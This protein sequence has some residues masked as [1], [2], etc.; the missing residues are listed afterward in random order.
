MSHDLVE[1]YQALFEPLEKC[2]PNTLDAQ[3]LLLDMYRNLLRN[4]TSSLESVDTIPAGAPC[5][6]IA[7]LQV[8]VGTV[9][10]AL[11]QAS[12][13]T[14]TQSSVLEFYEQVASTMSNPVLEPHLRIANPPPQLVYLIFFS[15]SLGNI[16][17]LTGILAKYKTSFDAAMA[18]DRKAY[19]MSDLQTYNGFLMDLCNCIWRGR[20]FNSSDSH[21][22]ACLSSPQT[23]AR[24]H[25]Y[26]ED[27][28][29]DLVLPVL[30]GLSHSPVLSLQ[31]MLC[32][33]ALEDAALERDKGAISTRHAGPVT[34]SSLQRLARAQGLRLEWNEY[35]QRVLGRLED[36]GFVGISELIRN[37]IKGR[38]SASRTSSQ[39]R[40]SSLG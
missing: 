16:S 36:Q 20:A 25:R 34:Q 35:R 9:A 12:P 15:P 39:P 26:I 37:V 3:I 33:L 18:R 13:G 2:L 6:S 21:A 4:W 5:H 8:H 11:V 28:G 22:L 23:T 17:R 30:F 24:F 7:E 19:G 1:L 27:L 40:Q 10:L 38:R 14:A 29:M 32:V 31:S